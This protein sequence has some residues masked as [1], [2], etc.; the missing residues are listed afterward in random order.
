[1]PNGIAS[2]AAQVHI[3]KM[4]LMI[5]IDSNVVVEEHETLDKCARS[6]GHKHALPQRA[7]PQM[8]RFLPMAP[9]TLPDE[10]CPRFMHRYRDEKYACSP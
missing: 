1:M 3:T 10:W 7:S 5:A 8:K 9:P 4:S 6:H 2:G